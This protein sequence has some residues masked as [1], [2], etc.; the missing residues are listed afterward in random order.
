MRKQKGM[1]MW[2]ILPNVPKIIQS[3]ISSKGVRFLTKPTFHSIPLSKLHVPITNQQVSYKEVYLQWKT[4][5]VSSQEKHLLQSHEFLCYGVHMICE[6]KDVSTH[7]T[8][9]EE[10]GRVK[11]LYI[12]IIY[13]FCDH[14]FFNFFPADWETFTEAWRQAWT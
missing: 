12:G 4:H 2:E 5:V 11:S 8:T 10:V 13:R 9:C 7:E 6:K 1:F 3:L 14:L